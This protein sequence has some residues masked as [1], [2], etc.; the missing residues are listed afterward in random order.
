MLERASHG[1]LEPSK[2]EKVSQGKFEFMASVLLSVE[3]S[4]QG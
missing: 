4:N 2:V 3:F 1:A